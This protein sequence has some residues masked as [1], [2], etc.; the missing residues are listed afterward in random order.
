MRP[1]LVVDASLMPPGERADRPRFREPRYRDR[2]LFDGVAALHGLPAEGD[3]AL[4]RR[5]PLTGRLDRLVTR[6]ATA[7][8]AASPALRHRAL[9]EVRELLH[10]RLDEPAA[11]RSVAEV[12]GE[13]GFL[14]QSHLDR[15]FRQSFGMSAGAL[16]KT[17][18]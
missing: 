11:G 7:P 18:R 13:L 1:L 17:V 16:A 15:H 5:S 6:H 12:A 2:D 10:E 4:T 14:H 8:D 3:D 9:P